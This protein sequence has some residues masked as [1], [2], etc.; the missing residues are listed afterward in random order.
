M[1]AV[2][3]I[4]HIDANFVLPLPIPHEVPEVADDRVQSLRKKL[5]GSFWNRCPRLVLREVGS[6]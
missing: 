1:E 2:E 3:D 6:E 4:A 5:S